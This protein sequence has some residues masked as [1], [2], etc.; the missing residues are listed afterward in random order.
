MVVPYYEGGNS[1]QF[2]LYTDHISVGDPDL[3]EIIRRKHFT[4][5]PDDPSPRVFKKIRV[6]TQELEE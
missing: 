4:P 1:L 3:D 5:A 2:D 6:F